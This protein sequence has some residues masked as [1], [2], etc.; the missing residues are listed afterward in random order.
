MNN[1]NTDFVDV[2]YHQPGH[3]KAVNTIREIDGYLF[4]GSQDGRICIWDINLD[5]EH[6]C[7]YAHNNSIIDIQSTTDKKYL[8]TSAQ[9]RKLKIWFFKNFELADSKEA[10]I[11]SMLGAKAWKEHVISASKDLQLKKWKIKDNKLNLVSKTRVISV[12]KYFSDEDKLYLSCA[13]GAKIVLEAEDFKQIKSLFVS[14]AKVLKLIRKASKYV[15]EF[16]KKDPHTLLFNISRRNG[17]S[18]LSFKSTSEFIIL[19]HE[20]GFVSIWNKQTLKLHKAFFVH[21]NHITGIELHG[22]YLYT[23]SLDSTIVKFDILKQRPEKR[24]RLPDKPFS[25][26][27]TTNNHIIVGLGNGDLFL[28]DTDLEIIK[29]HPGISLITS[30]DITPDSLI[31]A[32]NSGKILVLNNSNLEISSSIKL[33]NKRI[34]G[35]F[36]YEGNIIT[37]GEDNKI[38]VLDKNLNIIKEV[39][40]SKRKSDVRR[41]K[42]YVSLTPNHVFDLRK[43][44][45]I[46]GE[47]SNE[48]EIELKDMKPYEMIFNKGDVLFKVQKK[49]LQKNI[50]LD[51]SE[52]YSEEIIDSLQILTKASKNSFYQQTAHNTVLSVEIKKE[53]KL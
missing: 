22:N 32:L 18:I 45:V 43:Y 19:G 33:H 49:A 13:E 23:T 31:I 51:I 24:V 29:K 35:I 36:Y 48:T 21:G 34:L 37:V 25:L 8:I 52:Y 47:I 44:E 50:P 1:P 38:L 39:N 42:H 7:I 26:L 14:D 12:D 46:K 5:K 30:A 28:L 2:L 6:G 16:K 20:F 27:K 53:K 15:E 17:F 11:S 41:I 10:H 40:F 4:T 9:E 3:Q